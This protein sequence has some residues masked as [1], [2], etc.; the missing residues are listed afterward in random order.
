MGIKGRDAAVM[1]TALSGLV[2]CLMLLACGSALGAM[3]LPDGRAWEMVSPLGKNGGDIYGIR[4]NNGGGVVQAAA[5]GSAVTYLGQGTFLE[6]KPLGAVAN[7]YVSR[8]EPGGWSTQSI[9]TPANAGTY[10]VAGTG[11]PYKAFSPDLSLALLLNGEAGGEAAI[12][13]PP[14]PLELEPKATPGYQTFY[15]RYGGGSLRALLTAVPIAPP[16]NEFYMNLQG[17]SPD[18]QHVVVSS[19]AALTPGATF[20]GFRP[21]VYEWNERAGSTEGSWSA[22]NVLP[23][24]SNGETVPNAQLGSGTGESNTVSDDGAH[25]FWTYEE[26]LYVRNGGTGTAQIDKLQG[27][28]PLGATENPRPLFRTASADGRHA[29]FTSHAP[30]TAEANTGPACGSFC[31]RAGNDLYEFDV[32]TEEL[33]DLTPDHRPEDEAAGANVQGVIGAS[34]DGSRVYFVA[35]GVLAGVNSEGHSPLDNAENMYVASVDPAAHAETTSFVATLSPADEGEGNNAAAHD[36]SP[37]VVQRTARVTP[38]GRHVAFMSDA[39]LTGYSNVD[40]TT[41]ELDEQVYLYDAEAGRL[42]CAS[43]NPTGAAPLGRSFIPGG[44]PFES[45]LTGG[46]VYQSRALS[47]DGSRLFFNSGDALVPQD[48]NGQQDVYEYGGGHAYLISSGTSG[49]PSEFVNASADGGDVFFLTR[50][51]LVRGDT[52]QL[53]DLY[54]ARVEGGLPEPVLSPPCAGESCK[55]PSSSP[56]GLGASS[57]ETF[58]G[59]GNLV[60]VAPKPVAKPKPKPKP[61]RKHRSKPRK[62]RVKGRKAGHPRRAARTSKARTTAARG[63]G[64]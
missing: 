15:L 7:Q 43:C 13:N 62:T 61:R 64:Q 57:S 44:T 27:G 39:S 17:A 49:D 30:L 11:T 45:R 47:N 16:A 34:E 12:E 14:L 36:W 18:L 33:R 23:G 63:R 51:Q 48:T 40:A 53:V 20:A 10:G 24:V 1:S 28:P 6:P 59:A 22:V 5:E 2:A 26:A 56:P 35:R 46:A 29:F 41:E 50:Q 21:D 58:V 4:G 3:Q 38:D 31:Q 8:R 54:D 19:N 60:P 52:D 55:P 9:A 25:V 32:E 37:Q 42:E